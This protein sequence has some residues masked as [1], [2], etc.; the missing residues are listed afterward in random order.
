[1]SGL[2]K[3][4]IAFPFEAAQLPEF[5]SIVVGE[6]EIAF[7]E[8]V[9]ALENGNDITCIPGV[10]TCESVQKFVGKT[11]KRDKRFLQ[12][13]QV[14]PA[15]I[16]DIESLPIPNR[17]YIS[18][19]NYKSVI[20]VSK[21]LATMIS[22]RGCPYKCTFCDVPIKTHRRRDPKLVVDELSLIHI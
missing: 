5:D 9:N 12:K 7:T 8:L 17:K 3:H 16:D 19:I 1:M 21:K 10:Y 4:P 18:H 20:G 2:S 15:Y 11:M 14:P 22:S 6:G 13:V